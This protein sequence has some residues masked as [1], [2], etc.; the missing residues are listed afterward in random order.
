MR[1]RQLSRMTAD[2]KWKIK[3]ASEELQSTEKELQSW[4]VQPDTEQD[5]IMVSV[6]E[7]FGKN[8]NKSLAF[9]S[10]WK[11]KKGAM[12][13]TNA[14]DDNN[15]L[16][17]I[18]FMEVNYFSVFLALVFTVGIFIILPTG[19]VNL[20]KLFTDSVFWLN[21]AEGVF[22]ILLFVAYVWLISFMGE[23]KRVFQFHGAEHKTTGSFA[24]SDLTFTKERYLYFFSIGKLGGVQGQAEDI[25]IHAENLFSSYWGFFSIYAGVSPE[26][27]EE[28]LD[29]I[30]SCSLA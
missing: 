7:R 26:K 24:F 29:A 6:L 25:K 27:A 3:A 16:I 20:M 15:R 12:A 30:L 5:A 10:G 21:F 1:E 23:I 11:L 22:R 28:A 9:C 14:P 4:I 13:S 19:V 2:Q 17:A 8:G 18:R